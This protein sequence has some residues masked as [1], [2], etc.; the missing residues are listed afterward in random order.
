MHDVVRQQ[1]QDVP[2]KVHPEDRGAVRAE[3]ATPQQRVAGFAPRE[4]LTGGFPSMGGTKTMVFS[5]ERWNM[6]DV[7][8]WRWLGCLCNLMVVHHCSDGQ[9][10]L[11]SF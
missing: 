3:R 7:F 10:K 4:G 2:S 8:G 9:L 6:L 5:T 1:L 11:C